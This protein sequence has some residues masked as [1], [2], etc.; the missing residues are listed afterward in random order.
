M[1]FLS[2]LF[3]LII[4]LSSCT[5]IISESHSYSNLLASS[6]QNYFFKKGTYWI[7][8]DSISGRVDSC[9]VAYAKLDTF[10]ANGLMVEYLEVKMK[11]YPINNP[12]EDS[13]FYQLDIYQ[14]DRIY[15]SGSKRYLSYNNELY[16]FSTN[17]PLSSDSLFSSQWDYTA[18]VK[19][20]KSFVL[21]GNSFANVFEILTNQTSNINNRRTIFF[22][23]EYGL[24]K[25]SIH[26]E[27]RYYNKEDKVWELQRW[28][29]I[30]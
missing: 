8:R 9:Y 7:Y 29:V 10:N 20:N 27:D 17:L 14:G 16:F 24:V 2:K 3:V 12:K 22:N 19:E 23:E 18:S 5:K 6:K 15:F 13:V 28:Q 30:K 1:K 11:Q 4:L 25:M 26:T 21:F